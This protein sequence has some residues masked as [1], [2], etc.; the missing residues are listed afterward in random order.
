MDKITAGTIIRTSVLL[1]ALVNMILTGA[2]CGILP[3]DEA[4]LE[5]VIS[6]AAVI[7]T[8]GIA[9]WKNNSFSGAARE[10]DTVLR[11]IR[12]LS[13]AGAEAAEELSGGRGGGEEPGTEFYA[14]AADGEDEDGEEGEEDE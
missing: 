6:D 1:L 14:A 9:A 7:V 12:I 8:A 11:S 13:R 4:W 5:S 2:G 10:A 3:V